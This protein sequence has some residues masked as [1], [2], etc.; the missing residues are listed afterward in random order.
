MIFFKKI[1]SELKDK[2]ETK[3]AQS[4]VFSGWVLP[5]IL[6]FFGMI[7]F[8]KLPQFV[9]GIGFYK[10]FLILFLGI[11]INLLTSFSISAAA[12]NFNYRAGG[13]YTLL[14]RCFGPELAIAVTVLLYISQV[15]NLSYCILGS[16]EMTRV[17]LELDIKYLFGSI[18]LFFVILFSR[19]RPK[20]IFGFHI[21][22]F[23]LLIVGFY[24]ISKIEHN[25]EVIEVANLWSFSFWS[26]FAAFFPVITGFESALFS[27]D[28][29]K[30]AKKYFPL[31]TIGLVVFSFIVYL[32]FSYFLAEIFSFHRGYLNPDWLIQNVLPK[33]VLFP[34][35]MACT[36]FY[37]INSLSNA[38]KLLQAVLSDGLASNQLGEKILV[39][40][41]SDLSFLFTISIAFMFFS[42]FNF[43]FLSPLLTHFYLLAYAM[44]NLACFLEAFIKNPSWRPT[45]YIHYSYPLC[46]FLLSFIVMIIMDPVLGLFSWLGVF[47]IYLILHIKRFNK[48]FSDIRQSI[49]MYIV[50]F[51]TYRLN[52]Y[53]D[54]SVRAWRPQLICFSQNLTKMTPAMH[55]AKALTQEKGFLIVASSLRK[56]IEEEKIPH[57]KHVIKEFFFRAKINAI[58]ELAAGIPID[59]YIYQMING[60][61]LGPVKPN[62]VL[63]SYD[64]DRG[65]IHHFDKWMQDVENSKKNGLILCY[66]D[67][68]FAQ[69]YNQYLWI[70]EIKR[71]K[72]E[73]IIQNESKQQIYFFFVLATLLQNSEEFFHAEVVVSIVAA[74]EEAIESTRDYYEDFFSQKRCNFSLE[75]T[76]LN[77][78][79][80]LMLIS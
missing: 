23:T 21:A 9:I 55:I 30:S 78:V 8:Y 24:F 59:E 38:S 66:K 22:T 34:A 77:E 43:D 72:I 44:V 19:L 67:V 3:D 52:Q 54:F 41:E 17:Y 71:K 75:I 48:N 47:F 73:I 37:A 33:G 58:I 51:V 39:N 2:N 16:L 18:F 40:K 4:G 7:T 6:S 26:I 65:S 56:D 11:F 20:L 45:F 76:S 80:I 63:F 5:G 49:L 28:R 12:T 14:I 79:K 25:K 42:F 74:D 62:T 35:L 70:K 50:R 10:F 29:I 68:I 32:I 46:G 64:L 53:K 57:F 60:Y 15:I 31:V 36:F 61:G 13:L 27:I 69:E 1:I